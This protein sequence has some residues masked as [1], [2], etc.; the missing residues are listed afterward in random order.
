MI[1]WPQKQE[2]LMDGYFTH[3]VLGH[4]LGVKN[5]RLAAKRAKKGHFWPKKDQFDTPDQT[6]IL[7]NFYFHNYCNLILRPKMTKIS[8][9][10]HF[11]PKKGRKTHFW[12]PSPDHWVKNIFLGA[13]SG[14]IID[15]HKIWPKK[16]AKMAK[17]LIFGHTPAHFRGL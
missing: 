15:F 6:K 9:K 17:N 1:F 3:C 8:E 16:L 5:S 12:P 7:P 13:F 11:W 4:F 2:D 14:P 10:K